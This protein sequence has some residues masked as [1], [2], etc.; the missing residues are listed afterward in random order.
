M[1]N[2]ANFVALS[3]CCTLCA[4]ESHLNKSTDKPKTEEVKTMAIQ[5]LGSG[6]KKEV[7]TAAPATAASPQPGKKVT[8]H[9]TGWLDNGG[10]QGEKF[11]SSVDRG[12]PFSFIIGIGQVIQGWDKG[13]MSM[14]VGEKA[15]LTIPAELGYGTRGAGGVIPPNATLIFD[16][17]LISV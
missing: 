6:L 15:R 9:Y 17:E 12:T 10:K 7:L 11:D 14:K 13:V 1:K 4:C 8:V 3:A 5:E 2:V 16:V